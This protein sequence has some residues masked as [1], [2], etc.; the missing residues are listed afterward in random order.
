MIFMVLNKLLLFLFLPQK[1]FV[2][3]CINTLMQGSKKYFHERQRRWSG[4]VVDD[5]LIN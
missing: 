1:M 4:N 2:K 5:D 3:F